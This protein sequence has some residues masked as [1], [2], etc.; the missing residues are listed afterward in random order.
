MVRRTLE[1]ISKI[2]RGVQARRAALEERSLRVVTEHRRGCATPHE[3]AIW[4]FEM[5]SNSCRA[6]HRHYARATETDVVS[7]PNARPVYLAPVGASAKLSHKFKA[8]G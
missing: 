2:H 1:V 8:L 5:A 4:I 7:H 6:Q 3:R